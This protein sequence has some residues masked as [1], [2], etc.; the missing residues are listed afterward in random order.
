MSH[1]SASFSVGAGSWAE[2][3][4]GTEGLTLAE[5]AEA[6]YELHPGISLCHQCAGEL[7]DPEVLEL[8]SLVIDGVEYTYSDDT[9]SWEAST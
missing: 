1:V 8:T 4:I 2:G 9:E 3:E 6:A 5:V 7:S